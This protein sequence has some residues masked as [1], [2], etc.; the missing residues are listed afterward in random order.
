[1]VVDGLEAAEGSRPERIPAGIDRLARAGR[2]HEADEA[3]PHGTERLMVPL[4]P[5]QRQLVGAA[6]QTG[7]ARLDEIVLPEADR[8]DLV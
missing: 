8:A 2:P 5:D 7:P 1:M 3:F 6:G 4:A